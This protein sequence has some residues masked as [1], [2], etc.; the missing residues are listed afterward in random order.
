LHRVA[1]GRLADRVDDRQVRIELAARGSRTH[2]FR[3]RAFNGR[4]SEPLQKVSL[5]EGALRTVRWTLQV[6]RPDSPRVVVVDADRDRASKPE[7]CGSLD[8]QPR[9]L[10]QPA[11]GKPR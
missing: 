2:E 4:V 5:E 1:E 11:S 7:L 9:G 3:L 6:E 8:A 10:E